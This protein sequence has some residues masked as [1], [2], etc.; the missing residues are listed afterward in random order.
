M[1]HDLI[2]AYAD[3]YTVAITPGVIQEH[4]FIERQRDSAAEM[5]VEA[6]RGRR[7]R[8]LLSAFL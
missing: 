5:P 2:K 4:E 1:L 7:W 3:A 8:G 6:K